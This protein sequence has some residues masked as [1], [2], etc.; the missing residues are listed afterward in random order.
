MLLRTCAFCPRQ[1]TKAHPYAFGRVKGFL[2]SEC[3]GD[4]D[5]ALT[6]W[7]RKRLIAVRAEQHRAEV[8]K[9][10]AEALKAEALPRGF[11]K[12]AG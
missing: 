12:V 4:L 10:K 7:A 2:C 3:A 11:R 6:S 1:C 9:R 5:V 8:E